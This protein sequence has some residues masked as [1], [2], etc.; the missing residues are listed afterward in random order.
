MSPREAENRYTPRV[1]AYN[2]LHSDGTEHYM[3]PALLP[4]VITADGYQGVLIDDPLYVRLFWNS[5]LIA[6]PILLGQLLV[7]PLA[8]Y[9]FEMMRF[10]GKETLYFLYIMVMLMPLQLLM[11]PHY[12]AAEAL[13]Y[14]NTWWAIVLPGIFAPFGTF[15]IRQQLKGFD[16]SI[17][18]A[19]RLDGAS[20]WRVFR[21]MAL[22][23]VTSAMAALA[24]LTFADCW[25]IVDQAVV[26]IKNSFDEPLSV[27]LSRL[28]AGNPG[29]IFAIACI[30]MFPAVIVFALGREQM[31]YGISL[32][33]GEAA[34][35]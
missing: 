15:L 4:D 6:L 10:K 2:Y 32:S 33:A 35:L 11:V 12:I 14:N 20:E 21:H 16:R 29:Q 23:G 34:G 1:T 3:E 22:P 5:V 19:A 7:S 8:A 25:N 13:G 27:Y 31:A 30:Y 17:F 28:V 26:F 18:E 24:V 9:A